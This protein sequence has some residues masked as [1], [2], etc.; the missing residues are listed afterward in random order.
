[1]ALVL[2]SS[3]EAAT[4]SLETYV[5]ARA[6][7]MQGDGSRS[8]R[9]YAA[10]AAAD[11]A[12]QTIARRAIAAAIQ[13][14]QTDLAVSLARKLKPAELPVDA[15]LLLAADSLRRGKTN[16]AIGDLQQGITSTEAE[17]FAP[18]VRAWDQTRRGKPDGAAALAALPANSPLTAVAD[19]QRAAMLFALGK[20]DEAL[21]IAKKVVERRGGRNARLRLAYA[22]ALQR[23]KR[24][25]DARAMLIG[26]DE[27]L[28][29]GRTRLAAGKPLGM[30]IAS[31][32]EGFAELLVALA[33]DL[34]RDDQKELPI[35]LA[36]VARHAAPASSEPVILLALLLDG[37]QRGNDALAVVRTVR[38]D[39]LLR[40]DALDL[41][42][43]LLTDRKQHDL[44]LQVARSATATPGAAAADY[45]RLGNI[46]GDVD[47]HGEAAAAYGEAIARASRDGSAAQLWSLRLLRAASLEQAKRWPEAKQELE[48]AMRTEP[49]NPV[50][51][52]FLGYGKLERGEDLDAA[53]AMI[54]KASALRPEDASIT[55]SLGWALYK[56]G[57]LPEAIETLTRAAAGDVAQAEIHE[58]LGDALFASGRRIEGRFSW[59]AALLTAEDAAKTRLKGKIE[60]G[61]NPANAA[62]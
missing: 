20:P 59:E 15:R 44:A 18:L 45:A 43:R 28:V 5:E 23:L 8:A 11:P 16:D 51:L 60:A 32:A 38:S 6:A 48:T 55:D 12:D 22:D 39:D 29:G 27:A 25:D 21:P 58:H 57:R 49:D 26:G 52:N 47:R 61:L 35:S 7:E 9:L 2:A 3:A 24:P 14:G 1:M 53:E 17:L 10:M 34:G 50:L 40:G 41:E 19:E 33:V 56:R 30:A 4:P 36:Q 37:N 31:P 62:P 46:L 42:A 13:S 54:R